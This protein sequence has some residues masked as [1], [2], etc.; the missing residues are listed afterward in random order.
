MAYKLTP[1]GET[2][3]MRIGA[4]RDPE[5]STLYFMYDSKGPVELDEILDETH[6]DDVTAQRVVGRMVT[7]GYVKEV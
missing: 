1:L 3:A 7:K 4:S 6:M 2:R 5:S